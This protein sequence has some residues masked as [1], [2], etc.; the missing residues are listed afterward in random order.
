MMSS[1]NK[2]SMVHKEVE[3]CKNS[4]RLDPE[5]QMTD[6]FDGSHSG[7]DLGR[8]PDNKSAVPSGSPGTGY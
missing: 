2:G 6:K 5:S 8:S 7:V 4:V 1:D 3:M